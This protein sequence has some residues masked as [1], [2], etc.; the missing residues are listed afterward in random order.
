M[1]HTINH[2]GHYQ[3]HI[4][5]IPPHTEALA[6]TYSGGVVLLIRYSIPLHKRVGSHPIAGQD[7]ESLEDTFHQQGVLYND[8]PHLNN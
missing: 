8:T 6:M 2:N 7:N 3:G 4:T 5:V 1:D